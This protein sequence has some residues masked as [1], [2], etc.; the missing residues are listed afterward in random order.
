MNLLKMFDDMKKTMTAP[1]DVSVTPAKN[2]TASSAREKSY[3]MK[4]QFIP[5]FLI[6]VGNIALCESFVQT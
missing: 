1:L 2:N 4:N 3:G 5:L 6:N